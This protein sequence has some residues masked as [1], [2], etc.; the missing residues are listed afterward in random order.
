MRWGLGHPWRK[1]LYVLHQE[2]RRKF[3]VS[4]ARRPIDDDQS[5]LPKNASHLTMIEVVVG[6]KLVLAKTESS[7]RLFT[8]STPTEGGNRASQ[9]VCDVLLSGPPK[10]TKR[11]AHTVMVDC[12]TH[13]DA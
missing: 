8:R 13:F 6:P 5:A 11:P 4:A 10:P 12:V 2:I 9:S 1:F 7:P 3:V